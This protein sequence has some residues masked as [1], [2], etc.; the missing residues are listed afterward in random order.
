M[1]KFFTKIKNIKSISISGFSVIEVLV[2]C[3]IMS[4]ITLIVM[5]GASKGIELSNK[6]LRQVQASQLAEEG[7][8]SVKSIRDTN[9]STISTLSLNT[10]YYLTYN[11]NTNIW[12]LGTT[13]VAPV[14]GIFTRTITFSAV[15]RDTN[16]NIASTGTLDTGIKRVN[17]LVSWSS[18]GGTNSKNI[19]FY[20]TDIFN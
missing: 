5:S 16:D 11:T 8:E 1:K 15:N 3:L 6:A 9:W 10:N 13:P 20:L 7:V 18:E 4:T 17:V 12:S 19:T 2:A 14:D